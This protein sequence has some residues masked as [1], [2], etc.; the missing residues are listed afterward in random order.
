M[1][2]I[3]GM[4]PDGRLDKTC[5]QSTEVWTGTT[6]AIA[7]CM[8]GEGMRDEAFATVRSLYNAI[9]TDLGY[10]FQTPEVTHATAT[11]ISHFSGMGHKRT[12]PCYKL[13]A[14][15]VGLGHSVGVGAGEERNS[16]SLRGTK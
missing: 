14:P 8:L 4:R 11:L 6:Y 10:W 16:K 13:H 7:A 3:N 2:A 12:V 1:G 15:S 5:M 9:Y